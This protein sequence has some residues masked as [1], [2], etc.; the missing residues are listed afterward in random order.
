MSTHIIENMKYM[1][2]I[3]M[4]WSS[5]LFTYTEHR[6]ELLGKS[7]KLHTLLLVIMLF[8]CH[9]LV[10][11]GREGGREA[12]IYISD[13]LEVWSYFDNLGGIS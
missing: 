13:P 3:L 7:V 10:L 5:A 11:S 9:R 8:E 6:F 12:N 4:E 2:N 1:G